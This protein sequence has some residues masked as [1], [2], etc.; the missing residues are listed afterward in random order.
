MGERGRA[1][2]EVRLDRMGLV[3]GNVFLAR[4]FEPRTAWG[5]SCVG[6]SREKYD[7]T[8]ACRVLD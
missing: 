6:K 4:R 2:S 8:V 7:G 3:V 1:G 5:L